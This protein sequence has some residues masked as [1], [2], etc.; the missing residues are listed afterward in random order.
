MFVFN[1]GPWGGG[2]RLQGE[3]HNY[4]FIHVRLRVPNLYKNQATEQEQ[5]QCLFPRDFYDHNK[6]AFKAIGAEVCDL[7]KDDAAWVHDRSKKTFQRQW[8]KALI[9]S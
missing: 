2:G 4:P 9:S 1:K 6:F 5:I 8:W 3:V 7:K